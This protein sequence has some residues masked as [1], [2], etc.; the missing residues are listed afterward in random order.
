MHLAGKAEQTVGLQLSRR[1][2]SS[3][4]PGPLDFWDFV[5]LALRLQGGTIV[6]VPIYLEPSIGVCGANLAKLQAV[7]GCLRGLGV[8]WIVAGDFNCPPAALLA[9]GWLSEVEGELL[10]PEVAYTERQGGLIDY[11]VFG[12]PGIHR[13][14]GI[15]CDFEGGFRS[16]AGLLLEVEARPLEA[17]ARV[18]PTPRRFCHPPRPAKEADPNSKRSRRR[19]AEAGRVAAHGMPHAVQDDEDTGAGARC[20]LPLPIPPA[21]PMVFRRGPGVSRERRGLGL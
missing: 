5:P 16:H 21:A 6:V 11:A 4:V 18:L 3:W 7:G 17:E 10:V 9:S 15:R 8:D 2:N 13:P 1:G 19:A 12:G 14:G 20:A